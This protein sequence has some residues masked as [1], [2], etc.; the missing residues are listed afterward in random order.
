MFKAFSFRK[1]KLVPQNCLSRTETISC[2]KQG[3]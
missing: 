2:R 3:G 1:E